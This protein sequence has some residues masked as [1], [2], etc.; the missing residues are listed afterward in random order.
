MRNAV[1]I[2]CLLVL[3]CWIA[4]CQD[5]KQEEPMALVV[6]K[7]QSYP[8]PP[9]EVSER[10]TEVVRNWVAYQLDEND[11]Y[12]IPPRGGKDVSGSLADFHA[13][14]QKDSDTYTVCV[15]FLDGDNTY[16]VDFFIDRNEEGLTVRSAYLHK[17]NG[18]A[19]AG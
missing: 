18:K 5:A 16:D 9:P 6:K 1:C 13:V 4:A 11:V 14:H 8:D 2:V 7:V 3:V 17:I 10:I 19:V 15:D 12:N